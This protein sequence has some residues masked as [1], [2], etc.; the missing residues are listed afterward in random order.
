MAMDEEVARSD[1]EKLQDLL[2]STTSKSKKQ[3]GKTEEQH[4]TFKNLDQYPYVVWQSALELD[5]D[6]VQALYC[7]HKG[8]PAFIIDNSIIAQWSSMVSPSSPQ[9]WTD[10]ED[11]DTLYAYAVL[12]S[13]MPLNLLN[14]VEGQEQG[15]YGNDPKLFVY[16]AVVIF[17]H[18]GQVLTTIQNAIGFFQ[19]QYDAILQGGHSTSWCTLCKLP[20][21]EM[22]QYFPVVPHTLCLVLPMSQ[23]SGDPTVWPQLCLDSAGCD[24]DHIIIW[25]LHCMWCHNM[26]YAMLPPALRSN[27]NVPW[28]LHM[29]EYPKLWQNSIYTTWKAGCPGVEVGLAMTFVSM[30]HRESDSGR[31]ALDIA[32]MVAI[33][34]LASRVD[35]IDDGNESTGEVMEDD[36]DEDDSNDEDVDEDLHKMVT[37]IA[38]KMDNS[39]FRSDA[40]DNTQLEVILG[41]GTSWMGKVPSYSLKAPAVGSQS[42]M[43]MVS[44]NEEVTGSSFDAFLKE[45]ANRSGVGEL[46]GGQALLQDYTTAVEL[47]QLHVLANEQIS[48]TRHFDTKFSDTALALLQK[49]HEVFIGTGSIT[50]KFIDDMATIALNFIWDATAYKTELSASD[51]MAFMAGLA[52]IWGWIADLIKEASALKLTY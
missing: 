8:I 43:H 32:D 44:R 39:S 42:S 35:N 2:E 10:S 50:Q 5:W 14:V 27:M 30:S 41:P 20:C 7:P 38:T 31:L 48:I 26:D 23:P 47:K 15:S 28:E 18:P 4:I 1:V 34:Y 37:E 6:K 22:S 33:Q 52:C 49:I 13:L 29:E 21:Y 12:F 36:G 11:S 9:Q 17:V 51:G 46:M 3:K 45:H 40:E 19:H 25:L 24:T 16:S